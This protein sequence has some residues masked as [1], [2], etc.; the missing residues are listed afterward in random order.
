MSERVNDR[1]TEFGECCRAPTTSPRSTHV[2]GFRGNH[3][4]ET[5]HNRRLFGVNERPLDY[6]CVDRLRR[7]FVR[8][9]EAHGRAFC[10]FA[11][12]S[13]ALGASLGPSGVHKSNL[14]RAQG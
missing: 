4:M 6:I 1:A 3:I 14:D 12:D 7:L 10:P 9:F 13:A 11:T 5:K 8:G 2:S